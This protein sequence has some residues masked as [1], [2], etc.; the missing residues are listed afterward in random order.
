MFCSREI[1]LE[2]SVGIEVRVHS[3]VWMTLES[4]LTLLF[5]I[6][7][8]QFIS[9]ILTL[10]LITSAATTLIQALVVFHLDSCN[11]LL[12]GLPAFSLIPSSP[13]ST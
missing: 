5:L 10:L 6:L 7:H 9:Q 11:N 8:I 12:T 1:Q 3:W 2:D 13:F 4:T